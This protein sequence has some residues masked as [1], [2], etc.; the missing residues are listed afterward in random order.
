[1]GFMPTAHGSSKAI[2]EFDPLHVITNAV[3]APL[4]SMGPVVPPR[5]APSGSAASVG[6]ETPAASGA[7]FTDVARLPPCLSGCYT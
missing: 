3:G 1:M 7:S 2:S 6:L 5:D 4:A